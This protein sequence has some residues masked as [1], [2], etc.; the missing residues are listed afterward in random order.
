[1]TNVFRRLLIAVCL[2]TAASFVGAQ[3][4]SSSLSKYPVVS[5][6]LQPTSATIGQQLKFSVSIVAPELT[7]IS[8]KSSLGD[9]KET[10]WSVVGKPVE[11]DEQL[12]S[13]EWRRKIDYTIT[14]FETGEIPVPP[15]EVNYQPPGSIDPVKRNTAEL[16][17]RIASL[18]PATAE[19]QPLRDIKPPVALSYPK[20]MFQA[21]VAAVAAVIALIA[22]IIWRRIRSKVGGML[23][24][25]MALD[26]WAMAEIARTETDR[27]IEQKK[28]KEL[29]TRL[30]DTLR[31]Y[32][33]KVFGFPAWDMTTGELFFHL[34]D[35]DSEQ[36]SRNL[37]AFRDARVRTRELFDEADLVKFAKLIPEQS[38]CRHAI[39]KA[40]EI[41]RLTRYKLEPEEVPQHDDRGQSAPPPPPARP[42]PPPVPRAAD[43][44][45]MNTHVFHPGSRET[46]VS[47]GER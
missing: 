35:M 2:L 15:V 19:T 41:V 43:H 23:R 32:Y 11:T 4:T 21:A 25:Q 34:E 17:V 1:M 16:R 44:A 7:R 28:I 47:G 30:A 14:T 6:T 26:D 39:E 33:G 31:Q 36:P 10:T 13:K 12:G 9:A 20:W 8:V 42:V 37:P 38:R 18:L 45:E 5:A 22:W 27:L 24:P 3:E 40:R 29:Y 46:S